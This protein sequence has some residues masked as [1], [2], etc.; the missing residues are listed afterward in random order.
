MQCTW[1]SSCVVLAVV[2]AA[3]TI[4]VASSPSKAA[5]G[6]SPFAGRYEGFNGTFRVSSRGE[7][8]GSYSYDWVFFGYGGPKFHDQGTISGTVTD[9]GVL[10]IDVDGTSQQITPTRGAK[11]PRHYHLEATASLGADGDMVGDGLMSSTTNGSTA[12]WAYPFEFPRR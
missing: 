8:N 9:A 6:T 10:T 5:G 2:I 1:K 7:I 11:E 4:A 12:P 3:A